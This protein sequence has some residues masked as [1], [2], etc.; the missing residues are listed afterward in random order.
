M[1]Y[2]ELDNQVESFGDTPVNIS[3]WTHVSP[4]VSPGGDLTSDIGNLSN[5]Q[6]LVVPSGKWRIDGFPSLSGSNKGVRFQSGAW[7]EV[8][9]G[10]G[11]NHSGAGFVM[12][13][14]GSNVYVENLVIDSPGRASPGLRCVPSGDA[15]VNGY[16][17]KCRGSTSGGDQTNFFTGNAGSNTTIT[18]DNARCH[19]YGDISNY[20]QGN[21]RVGMM[22]PQG[23]A[24]SGEIRV[25]N[26]I[27]TG[28]PNNGIYHRSSAPL[29]VEG[30]LF[31]NNNVCGTR[32][33]T[34]G[35]VIDGATIAVDYN[36]YVRLNSSPNLTSLQSGFNTRGHWAEANNGP[37]NGGEMQNC[38][39]LFHSVYRSAG[40]VVQTNSNNFHV[41]DSQ[42]YN[43]TSTSFTSGGV[44]TSNISHRGSLGAVNWDEVHPVWREAQDQGFVQP[45]PYDTIEVPANSQE[46]IELGDND[47]F[48]Y[49]LI[50][51]RA[52]N[53]DFQIRAR[54]DGWRIRNIGVIGRADRGENTSPAGT[55]Y[56]L[57][58]AGEGTIDYCYFGDGVSGMN[59]VDKGWLRVAP[60][61][62]ERIRI[63][64]CYVR[65]WAMGLDAA[66][67]GR[68]VGPGPTDGAGGITDARYCYMRDNAR[69]HVAA[70]SAG[71]YYEN[72]TIL[73]SGDVRW[74][75]DGVIS[76]GFWGRY[77]DPEQAVTIQDCET[78]IVSG[79]TNGT[80]VALESTT[81]STFGETSTLRVRGGNVRGPVVGSFVDV[82]S[83]V[84]DSPS[85]SIP[86]H[87]P[88]SAE[89]AAEG[90][91]VDVPDEP[92]FDVLRAS[93]FETPEDITEG[94]DPLSEVA[95]EDSTF[96][97]GGIGWWS[98]SSIRHTYFM[99]NARFVDEDDI[100][101]R[102]PVPGDEPDPMPPSTPIE[103]PR[104]YKLAA[105]GEYSHADT[106]YQTQFPAFVYEQFDEG[107][108]HYTAA[109]S[110][111]LDAFDDI[112]D[113]ARHGGHV[114]HM[115]ADQAGTQVIATDRTV[116]PSGRAP[117]AP[118]DI[119]FYVKYEG[120]AA[121][122]ALLFG[123]KDR[124]DPM[125]DCYLCW[126]RPNHA[127][128]L[129]L[130]KRVSGEA[131]ITVSSTEGSFP[132]DQWGRVRI[133]WLPQDDPDVDEN[134][135]H[136]ELFADE[137]SDTP[138]ATAVFDE[139]TD[140]PTTPHYDGG[141]GWRNFDNSADWYVDLLKD[142]RATLQPID[143]PDDPDPTIPDDPDDDPGLDPTTNLI[144]TFGDGTLIGYEG[145][146]AGDGSVDAWETEG[147]GYHLI[148]Y[149]RFHG[150]YA[151][152]K[153]GPADDF[154]WIRTTSARNAEVKRNLPTR[155]DRFRVQVFI[156]TWNRNRAR[157]YFG[158]QDARNWYAIEVNNNVNPAQLRLIRQSEAHDPERNILRTATFNRENT[159]RR[160][161]Y[162]EV[163]W[164]NTITFSYHRPN[165]TEMAR[166]AVTDTTFEDGEIGWSLYSGRSDDLKPQM[167]FARLL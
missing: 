165:G 69:A 45:E 2:L 115:L 60:S 103:I 6:L 35:S 46:I 8:A 5:G 159:E 149:R 127:E 30:G 138:V 110:G 82:G 29:M 155:G 126:V 58:V 89:E 139:D 32:T 62:A 146:V 79:N 106:L 47:D 63:R 136:A 38:S 109:S 59:A 130:A 140:A 40:I 91:D 118:G 128:P 64:R 107:L 167:D 158:V 164:R 156:R 114:L 71:D 143:S 96:D 124:T 145:P 16:H 154:G 61:H 113:A 19:N 141:W 147:E 78:S 67:P 117:F 123:V 48:S 134:E 99:D 75:P 24:T 129:L 43:N 157:F 90:L 41:A 120:S 74:G 12:N 133:R 20:G 122:M 57:N 23:G 31:A 22:F 152:H 151:L 162:I 163:D 17:V 98:G 11:N 65:G 4:S 49:K 68:T 53:A 54:G 97:E 27:L 93:L 10:R 13:M 56:M 95:L 101:A 52:D 105:S 131:E 51:I 28:F 144:E 33:T 153:H 100:A 121:P 1:A 150:S 80:P 135:I 36:G 86:A 14:T 9:A 25:R 132:A 55:P 37:A 76:R 39:F 87:V 21:T 137:E 142:T 42:V 161:N 85:A 50:D 148:D 102:E 125:E 94:N 77:G 166:G 112:E 81:R 15:W 111:D 7:V 104:G 3:G 72:I 26:G 44:S 34:P 160:W 119:E 84:G 18:I 116:A 108:G 92:V 88:T 66:A 73:N 83:D 70:A